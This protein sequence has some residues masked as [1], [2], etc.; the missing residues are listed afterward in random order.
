MGALKNV[1]TIKLLRI[2]LGVFFVIVGIFGIMTNVDESIFRLTNRNINLEIIFGIV[3][4]ICGLLILLGLFAFS[5]FKAISIGG[6]VVFIF[7]LVRIVLTK[8]V[9]CFSM[10]NDAISFSFRP[11]FYSWL[12]TLAVELII[13]AALLVVIKKYD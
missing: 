4:V 12:L 7:W 5:S 9:W 6:T 2:T 1:Y 13:A 8:F 3:E 11:D 10:R